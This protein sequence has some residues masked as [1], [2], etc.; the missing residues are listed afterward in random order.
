MVDRQNVWFFE[1]GKLQNLVM[2]FKS[3]ATPFFKE[4]RSFRSKVAG[5][6]HTT[7]QTS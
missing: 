1:F 3:F 5:N 2:G 7:Y 6:F 4:L